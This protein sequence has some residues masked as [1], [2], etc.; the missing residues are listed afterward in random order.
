MVRLDIRGKKIIWEVIPNY[1]YM[2]YQKFIE[3]FAC[4]R[5]LKH[6]HISCYIEAKMYLTKYIDSLIVR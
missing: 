1:F 4:F 3:I 6:S 2:N 5:D